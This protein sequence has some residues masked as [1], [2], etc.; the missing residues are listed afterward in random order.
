MADLPPITPE[1]MARIQ[2][3]VRLY[4]EAVV[5]AICGEAQLPVE[6]VLAL[7][8]A[9]VPRWPHP[10][11][12][13]QSGYLG[14]LA[15]A[16]PDPLAL[17]PMTAA[18]LQQRVAKR[19]LPLSRAAALAQQWAAV[20]A[21]TYCRGLGNRVNETTGEVL[22][23]VDRAQ[24][25]RMEGLIREET[26]QD[27]HLQETADQLRSRIGHASGDWC[28]DLR[29]IANTEL[30]NAMEQGYGARVA[31]EHGADALVAKVPNDNAC[32]ACKR[33]YLGPDGKPRIFKLSEIQGATNA[34]DPERPGH[35]RRQADWVPTLSVLHP[36]C[37]CKCTWVPQGWEFDA[38]WHLVPVEPAGA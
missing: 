9:G 2:E 20:S 8:R 17:T 26:A 15:A 35:G 23:E 14:W 33:L 34:V 27:I 18:E 36:H 11:L 21:A 16:I 10:A 1:Q 22:I 29:R 31:E 28:R 4:H 6:V 25:Q 24:R 7:Q 38:D 5:A 37:R 3:L 30:H 12:I 19:P 32:D 13:E